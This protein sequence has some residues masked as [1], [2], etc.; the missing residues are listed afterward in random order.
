[1]NLSSITTS[2]EY[3]QYVCNLIGKHYETKGFEYSS[4][5]SKISC[6]S[7]DIKLEISFWSS[8]SNMLGDYI[9]LEII[10]YFYSIALKKNNKGFLFS[11]QSFL[12]KKYTDDPS[13]IRIIQIYGDTLETTNEHSRESVIKENNR[14]NVNDFSE[15]KLNK[16]IEF[17]DTKII[18]WLEKIKTKE[19][20]LELTENIPYSVSYNLKSSQNFIDYCNTNFP[21]IDILKRI[22][23]KF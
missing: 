19:G 17:I 3:F 8:R 9:N 12:V 10:P 1:M 23:T 2:K 15:Q 13:K 18:Y 16:I 20:I 6:I 22:E 11:N 7:G 21:S 4:S 5:R 14:C